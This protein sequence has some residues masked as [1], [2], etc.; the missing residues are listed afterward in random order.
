[1]G[2]GRPIAGKPA[3][4]DL[5]TERKLVAL[6]RMFDEPGV[7]AAGG[8]AGRISGRRAAKEPAAYDM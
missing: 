3:R 6:P 2:F 4:R 1:L 7:A 5:R 8:L